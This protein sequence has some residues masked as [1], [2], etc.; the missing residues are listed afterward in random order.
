[1]VRPFGMIQQNPGSLELF[2]RKITCCA[3]R[4]NA[5]TVCQFLVDRK[6]NLPYILKKMKK[7]TKGS[8][9]G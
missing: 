1:M 4:P 8:Q 2:G 5:P 6:M 9:H 3:Q 7:L